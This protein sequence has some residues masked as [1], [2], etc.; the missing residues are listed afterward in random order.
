MRLFLS[1]DHLVLIAGNKERKM[2]VPKC[3]R[4]MNSRLRVFCLVLFLIF[5]NYLCITNLVSHLSTPL[6]KEYKIA[7]KNLDHFGRGGEG[8]G[9]NNARSRKG[10][11]LGLFKENKELLEGKKPENRA[12][13][14]P[15]EDILARKAQNNEKVEEEEE[16]RNDESE[17]NELEST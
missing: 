14:E 7:Q 2:A 6:S 12:I 16:A 17:D 5:I 13:A 4:T 3:F 10:T 8:R 11:R 9:V 1:S 15:L